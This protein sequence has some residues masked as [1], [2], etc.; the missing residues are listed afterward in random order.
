MNR[1]V[2]CGLCTMMCQCR[3]M[4]YNKCTILAEDVDGGGKAGGG[5][6]GGYMGTLYLLLNF[7]V[8]LH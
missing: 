4:S 1:N 5:R 2:N 7:A 3:F 6:G 8:K